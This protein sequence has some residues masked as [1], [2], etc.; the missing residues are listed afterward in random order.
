MLVALESGLDF[1]KDRTKNRIPYIRILQSNVETAS[2]FYNFIPKSKR[3]ALV[4]LFEFH[5][6]VSSVTGWFPL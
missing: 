3:S 1:G 5:S 4:N 6:L 2:D